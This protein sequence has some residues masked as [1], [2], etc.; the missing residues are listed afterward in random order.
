MIRATTLA[1]LC[2]LWTIVP[3]GAQATV[4]W[5]EA[6]AIAA[7]VQ[8]P[9]IPARHIA[10]TH[11][12]AVPDGKT[13]ARPAIQSTIAAITRQGGGH[14]IIPKGR[15]FVKGPV[16][17]QSRIDLHLAKGAELR[18][19]PDPADFLPTVKIRWEG[20]E[21]QGYAPLIY[22]R[23]VEDVAITGN[24]VIDGNEKSTFLRWEE[25]SQPDIARARRMAFED[26]PFEQRIF[27]EGTHLRPS[28]V[29]IIGGK[30]VLLQ[31][32]TVKNASFWV[33][34]LV[35]V[36]HATIRRIRVVSAKTET[37][38]HNDGV[39][40]DSSTH[41][42]VEGATFRCG[43][44]SVAIKSGRDADGRRIG[45][46]SSDIVIRNNDLGGSD[47]IGFGSE[48]SG[49]IRNVY[50]QNNTMRDAGAAF[51]FKSTLQRGGV[52]ENIHVRNMKMG[53]Y[54]QFI[55]LQLGNP[56][57]LGDTAHPAMF[58]NISFEGLQAKAAEKFLII[59]G[60]PTRPISGVSLRNIRML[61]AASTWTAQHVEQLE[62]QN[63]KVGNSTM[64]QIVDKQ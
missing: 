53:S 62:F 64:N 11:F 28:A 50:V 30:R 19:S 39:D 26:T 36:D 63:V 32:Y 16:V 31:G 59:E 8:T 17:L 2:T 13:D 22:G 4:D 3:A 48:M 12:G 46:P 40:I 43:N 60:P 54:Q 5:S 42:L 27:G 15:W 6:D 51:H 14:V 44:Y 7:A 47:G 20:I 61:K 29:E 55:W 49:G 9:R 37:Q 23:D 35:Y 1:L 56:G 38:M 18:F 58:R 10:I 25:P 34:Q 41:V 21:I 33:N 52:V 45:R 57:E 24:G